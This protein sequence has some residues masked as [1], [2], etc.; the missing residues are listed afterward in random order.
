MQVSVLVVCF[1]RVQ[2]IEVAKYVYYF[3]FSAVN[4]VKVESN[5]DSNIVL[6]LIHDPLSLNKGNYDRESA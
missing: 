3:Q 6:N 1:A 2:Y 5:F 4:D